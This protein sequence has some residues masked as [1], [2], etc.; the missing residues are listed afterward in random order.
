MAA[1]WEHADI[2]PVVARIIV[3][4][5]ASTHG[6]VTHD[7]ITAALLADA[8]SGGLIAA[9][10][11]QL[12]EPQSEE[13]IAHNMVAWFSQRITVNESNWA[14]QFER[15]KISGKWAYRPKTPSADET[16]GDG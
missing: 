10:K 7:D 15:M 1:S 13:W 16:P 2:F 3:E 4:R 12:E 6:F 5:F 9:A 8:E 11:V 14:D